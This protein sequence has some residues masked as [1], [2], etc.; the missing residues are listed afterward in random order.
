VKCRKI[1]GHVNCLDK[2]VSKNLHSNDLLLVSSIDSFLYSTRIERSV[3]RTSEDVPKPLTFVNVHCS[4]ND[5]STIHHRLITLVDPGS[6]HSII[7][8]SFI[9]G[10]QNKKLQ[11]TRVSYEVAGGNFYTKYEAKLGICLPKFSQTNVV[12][13]RYA[14]DDSDGQGLGYDFIISQDFCDALGIDVRYS[15]C[16]TIQMN[17]RSRAM[18]NSNFPI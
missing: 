13:H 14:I 3:D 15:D 1:S 2:I 5:F 17:G 9:D 4:K 11:K 8:C 18:K 7:R 10:V 16:R 12:R 6:T